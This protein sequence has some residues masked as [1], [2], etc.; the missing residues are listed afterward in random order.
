MPGETWVQPTGLGKEG[1]TSGKVVI[2]DFDGTLGR[3]RG[4]W[5]GASILE[6]LDSNQPGHGVTAETL[7]EPLSRGFPWHS[8]E[9]P[10][11]HLNPAGRWWRHVGDILT[12]ALESA[13]YSLRDAE[14]LTHHVRTRFVDLS[15]WEAFEDAVPALETMK[16][17]G[18]SNLILSNH[19]PE[20]PEIVA[21]LPI[22]ELIDATVSSANV[23]YEKPHRGAFEAALDMA[24][25]P[26]EVWMVGDNPI[27]DV[28]GAES[29]GI[30]AI[31]VRSPEWTEQYLARIESTWGGTSWNGWARYVKRKAED[32]SAVPDMI[33]AGA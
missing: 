17:R 23:G 8:H 12:A 19:I 6:F 16:Q 15:A 20:L 18:W 14:A 1:I 26:D 2:W 3:R 11:P 5:W 25:N 21:A 28:A 9:V 32:L 13:G 29:L 10:H 24:G 4:G 7:R 27:A 31:L 30:P 22:E 33:E